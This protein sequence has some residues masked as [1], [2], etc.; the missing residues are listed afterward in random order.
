MSLEF[1]PTIKSINIASEDLTKITLEVK[2]G[3][4]DGKYD[5]LRKLSG[6]TVLIAVLPEEYSYVQDYDSS[7]NKPITE[8]II[9]QDG[10]AEV[11]K[12]EQTQLDVDGQGNIDIKRIEKKVAKELIDEY[13]R[14]ATT[15]EKPLNCNINPRDVILSLDDGEEFSEIADR[16]EM[17]DSSLL[18]EIEKARQYYAPFADYWNKHKDDIV[19]KD[20][21]EQEDSQEDENTE[22]PD[23]LEEDSSISSDEVENE[24]ETILEGEVTDEE[25]EADLSTETKEPSTESEETS[26][27]STLEDGGEDDPY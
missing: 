4:L 12:T 27:E 6:K 13:I 5:T 14:Q 10:T 19:F 8:W 16:Y 25:N 20:E 26:T 15:L 9:N 22:E 3:S 7:T 11:R 1:K 24:S 23:A 2:N 17:S 18:T 21:E